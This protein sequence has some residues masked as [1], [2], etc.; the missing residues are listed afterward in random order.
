MNNKSFSYSLLIWFKKNKRQMP[1]RENKNFYNIWL[2][3]I[4]LQQTQVKTVIPYFVKWIKKF[5]TIKSIAKADED[6]ILKYWEGL[7]YYARARNFKKACNDIYLKNINLNKITFEEFLSFPGV[8]VYTAS[9]VFSIAKNQVYHVVDGNVKR[10]LSR[11]LRLKKNPNFHLNEID[12]FLLKNI[13]I[14]NPGDF[15]QALM[16]LGAMICKP[17]NAECK[18][19][20]I[21]K[22]CKGYLFNDYNK[23]PV[24]IKKKKKPH[25]NIVAG[26][27]WY[28]NKIIISK[29]K[30]E[31]LLGG[32]WEFPGGKI[33]KNETPEECIKR[34]VFEEIN[35]NI[36]VLNYLGQIKH[37]YS[38]FSITLNS[39]ECKYRS[40]K[41]KAV[42][43]SDFKKIKLNDLSKYAFP[44]ANHKIFKIL[45]EYYN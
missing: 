41:I 42:E 12:S 11:V 14:K 27:I 5:P 28:N 21:S 45:N 32:L 3:E 44:K 20:P 1:W 35:I 43:C 38:H 40:G 33:K 22:F 31:G 6:I 9:A 7:G 18:I 24:K 4:M 39:Y 16:E 2:S 25:Y 34:E 10:V 26:I 37:E 36:D 30:S 8:G 13:S 23:Y 19:C 17:N 15:N 29:R